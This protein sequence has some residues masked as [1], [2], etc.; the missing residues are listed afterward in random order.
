MH[1]VAL[2]IVGAD[3]VDFGY[4][5]G[6]RRQEELVLAGP[7]GATVLRATQ[8][9]EFAAQTLERSGRIVVVPAMLSQPIAV[10]EVAQHL[11]GLAHGEPAGMAP[12]IAGPEVQRMPAMVRRVARGRGDRRPI[13]SLRLPGRVGRGFAGGGL[14][15][16]EPGPR[17]TI[18]FDTWLASQD[19]SP[20]AQRA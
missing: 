15:P 17:G 1:H 14:L 11:A 7:I 12:E 18:T 20:T 8:F 13:L 10:A 4:Y 16:T 2:S 19:A 9:H 5:L 6:K 3:R